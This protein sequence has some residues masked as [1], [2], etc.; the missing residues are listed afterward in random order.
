MNKVSPP[1]SNYN[2]FASSFLRKIKGKMDY[3]LRTPAAFFP[4]YLE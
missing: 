2:V 4:N 1:L 3:R